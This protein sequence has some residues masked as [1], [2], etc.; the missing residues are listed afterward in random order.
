MSTSFVTNVPSLQAQ[1]NL[2]VNSEFQNKTIQR[3]TSGYRINV[4][5]DDAAG[6]AVANEYRSDITEITQ[7]VRNANDGLSVL[8]I[9]DGGLSNIAKML[10]RMRTLATQS[11]SGTFT[12]DRTT[13][14]AE[15][16]ALKTEIDRQAANIGLGTGTTTAGRFNKLISVFIGGG[17]GMANSQVTIDLSGTGSL[18]TTNALGLAGTS[19]DGKATST[20]LVAGTFDD[21]SKYLESNSSQTFRFATANS[22][23]TVTVQGDADGI[24]GE[25]IVTQLNAGLAG[26]GIAVSIDANSHDLVVSSSSSFAAAIDARTGTGAQISAAV[27]DDAAVVNSG[28]YRFAGGTVSAAGGTGVGTVTFT[29]GSETYTVTIDG[30]NA[31]S[32]DVLFNKTRVALADSSIEVIRLG[33]EIYF[34]SGADF[35]VS[36][37]TD[38]VTGGF[39]SITSGLATTSATD[40]EAATDETASA[41]AAVT[42]LAAAIRNLGRIQGQVG[43]AQNKLQYAINLAQSQIASFSA[44]ESRIR[45]AD[46]A[47]EAANLTRAQVTQQASLAATLQANQAP[48]AMLTLLRG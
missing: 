2:R 18:V 33:N 10:D 13:L 47:A 9:I 35:S 7:G 21:G 45:D 4:S 46:I 19:I 16:A 39:E 30:G 23:Y 14:N 44:A 43:T 26:S 31:D 32:V 5:G 27:A 38:T 29:Q 25:E 40:A 3:L 37:T 12:G 15:Y 8:Q 20:T 11:A 1:D 42:A 41:R 36:R 17:A 34:Q 24:T 22:T 6:L 28:R 48:Q